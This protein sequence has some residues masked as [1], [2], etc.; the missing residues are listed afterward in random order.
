[1]ATDQ[2]MSASSNFGDGRRGARGFPG[3]LGPV[4]NGRVLGVRAGNGMPTISPCH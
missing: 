3:A 2:V 4:A 1:M